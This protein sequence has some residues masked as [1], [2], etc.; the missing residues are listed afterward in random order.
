MPGPYPSYRQVLA[1]I[2][3]GT[4]TL[5]SSTEGYTHITQ[6]ASTVGLSVTVTLTR[7]GP[8]YYAYPN[9]STTGLASWWTLA[10]TETIAGTGGVRDS[11]G[12]TNGTIAGNPAAGSYEDVDAGIKRRF[13]VFDGTGDY[14][15]LGDITALDS[16]AAWSI[17]MRFRP[18][19]ATAQPLLG[20]Y[21]SSNTNKQF[22][23]EITSDATI[24]FTYSTNASGGVATV[25]TAGVLTA[26][27]WYNMLI[28]HNTSSSPRTNIYLDNVDQTL[29]TVGTVPTTLR[30]VSGNVYIA[31][32]EASGAVYSGDM[33]DV[34]YWSSAELSSAQ[35]T[36]W[37]TDART[38]RIMAGYS[39][40]PGDLITNVPNNRTLETVRGR[41]RRGARTYQH[42][43][44]ANI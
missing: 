43:I 41:G 23:V 33:Y 14:V 39:R 9:W 15:D 30:S 37:H 31:R 16:A 44:T 2:K 28:T 29:T 1:N 36:A 13:L 38:D 21:P 20:R 11:H 5:E 12:S 40:I 18:D 24:K 25:E 8:S 42:Q 17:G 19:A 4:R 22:L 3:H 34:T 27:T 7:Y 32:N 10:S 26:D 6:I 35:A